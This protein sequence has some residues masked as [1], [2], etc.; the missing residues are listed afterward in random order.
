V[1]KLAQTT[2]NHYLGSLIKDSPEWN[3]DVSQAF[4]RAKEIY[5]RRRDSWKNIDESMLEQFLM[6]HPGLC[7]ALSSTRH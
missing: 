7:Y 3:E 2:L 1:V 6:M 5:E 4:A